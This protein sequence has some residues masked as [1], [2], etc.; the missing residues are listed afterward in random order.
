MNTTLVPLNWRLSP[1]E[2]HTIVHDCAPRALLYG[3]AYADIAAELA[4]TCGIELLMAFDT[5]SPSVSVSP[6]VASDASVSHLQRT[7]LAYREACTPLA[8]DTEVSPAAPELERAALIL[9]TSGTTG[10]PKGVMISWRQLDSNARSTGALCTLG[11]A[12]RTLVFLPLF[13]TGGLNCL[14]TPILAAGGTVVL[15]PEFNADT[16]VAAMEEYEITAVIAV[17]TIYEMLLAAGIGARSLPQLRWLLMGGAPP[18]PTL[19]DAYRQHGL[20]IW[21]G[22]GLTEVGPNCFDLGIGASSERPT[23]SVGKPIPGT[24]ARLIA[25][26]GA[27]VIGAGDGE[28]CLRGPHV[29]LGYWNQPEATVA[30]LHTD[31]WFHTGDIARR[32]DDG[33][34]YIIGRKKD[35]FISGGENVYPAEVERVLRLHPDIVEAAVI[36]VPDD[37]WGE[38]GLAAV[39]LDT[40]TRGDEVNERIARMLRPW[41]RER[42]A[43]YKVPKRFHVLAT[44]PKTPTGK[45]AKSKLA[46]WFSKPA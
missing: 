8:S 28:L 20:P 40:Q 32:D 38:I 35:M 17:P 6:I 23:G 37:R 15:M 4:T 34:Y 13:H 21:Q 41:L 44:L 36:G 27:E 29:T 5:A 9:Y 7:P 24:D 39:V 16:A 31:G 3:P 46:Q 30:V 43:G 26:D 45:I 11:P 10:V 2:L 12:D 1:A 18:A 19:V 42:L 22:Y 14:A 33:F 25:D